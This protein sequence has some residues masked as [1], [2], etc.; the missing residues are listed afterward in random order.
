[1]NL[2]KRLLHLVK[3]IRCRRSNDR[4]FIWIGEM[5]K[6]SALICIQIVCLFDLDS[7]SRNK[8]W[9]PAARAMLPAA[10]AAGKSA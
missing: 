5:C 1:M 6:Q 8:G 9:D 4:L 3:A 2:D 7:R 10:S